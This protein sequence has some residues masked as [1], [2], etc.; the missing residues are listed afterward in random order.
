MLNAISRKPIDDDDDD[1]GDDDDVVLGT[2]RRPAP[3]FQDTFPYLPPSHYPPN[4]IAPDRGIDESSMLY[5]AAYPPDIALID[6]YAHFGPSYQ[7]YLQ[8]QTTSS[9]SRSDSNAVD[10]GDGTLKRGDDPQDLSS[11]AFPVNLGFAAAGCNPSTSQ[12]KPIPTRGGVPALFD[13]S[14]DEP[15]LAVGS[16]DSLHTLPMQRLPAA[17]AAAARL[18]SR[19]MPP[20]TESQ[21]R[22]LFSREPELA[23]LQGFDPAAAFPYSPNGS[24]LAA[25]PN[26][27]SAAY[28]ELNSNFTAGAGSGLHVALAGDLGDV[29]AVGDA[30][31]EYIDDVEAGS[32]SAGDMDLD[33]QR[34]DESPEPGAGAGGDEHDEDEKA[35][36]GSDEDEQED[37]RDY[38]KG[39][40]TVVGGGGEAHDALAR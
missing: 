40:C 36:A 17:L 20:L 35:Q 33:E 32:T 14:G 28:P 30:R 25:H 22:E 15:P 9:T 29:G 8:Q 7:Q 38:V 23:T 27:F 21:L 4:G 31:V 6:Q 19:E 3:V 5:D 37:P 1:E 39:I 10:E 2:T 12:S 13:D 16:V 34:V 24:A 11:N 26:Y 18:G